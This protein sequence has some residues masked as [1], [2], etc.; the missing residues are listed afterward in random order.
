MSLSTKGRHSEVK[1]IGIDLSGPANHKDTA[2]IVFNRTDDGRLELEELVVNANDE[3][4]LTTILTATLHD[5]DVV[6]G[7][8]APLSFQDGGGDRPQDKSLRQFM[9]E[10]GLSGSSV[11]PPTL[12]RMVYLTL[13]GI[14]LTRT[15]TNMK[16]SDKVR[17]VE[18][19]PGAAIG[20]RIGSE[21]LHH[22]LR[23]ICQL[24]SGPRIS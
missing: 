20:S 7:I 18:V 24:K 3:K 5:D 4:L 14:S 2:L 10:C 19:H 21:K 6:V 11:M 17:I 13:R 9:K 1:V 23:C 12:T 16:M 15:I 22:A 8:D